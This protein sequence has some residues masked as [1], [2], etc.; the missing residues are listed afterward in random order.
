MAAAIDEL[1]EHAT[2]NLDQPPYKFS[3][4]GAR[5]H[6]NQERGY[7]V[8]GQRAE[9]KTMI[10][11]DYWNAHT[12]FDVL[13]D[14]ERTMG[15]VNTVLQERPTINNSEIRIRYTGNASASQPSR[16]PGDQ[17]TRRPRDQRTR[18]PGSGQTGVPR[19]AHRP[20]DRPTK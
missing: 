4:W 6:A 20:A 7:H 2:S 18:G 5:Y 16:G 1:E 14:H 10:I 13:L 8:Q 19:P 15:Y 17:G 3:G 12:A 11:E 9:G